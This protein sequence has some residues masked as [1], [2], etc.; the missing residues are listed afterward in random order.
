MLRPSI[1]E[2]DKKQDE[3]AERYIKEQ[4]DRFCQGEPASDAGVKF[5]VTAADYPKAEKPQPYCQSDRQ[6]E[7]VIAGCAWPFEQKGDHQSKAGGQRA[8]PI[9]QAALCRVK[10]PGHA[11][12]SGQHDQGHPTCSA[13]VGAAELWN[14]LFTI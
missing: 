6:M 8:E 2:P 10:P 1:D 14:P 11:T 12:K 3:T 13:H 4:L 7:R 5:C 9:G